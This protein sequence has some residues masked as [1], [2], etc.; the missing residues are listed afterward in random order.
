MKEVYLIGCHISNPAGRSYLEDLCL[1]LHAE[2][3]DFV[4]SSHTNVPL[5]C[6]ELS[7]GFIYNPDNFTVKMW[8]LKSKGLF[9]YYDSFFEIRSNII[10]HGS[11]LDFYGVAGLNLLR[12]GIDFLM[13]TDYE[14]IHWIEYD[15]ELNQDLEKEL[16]LKINDHDA[17]FIKQKEGS[18]YSGGRISFKKSRINPRLMEKSDQEILDS[19]SSVNYFTEAFTHQ[20]LILGNSFDV[21]LENINSMNR[22]KTSSSRPYDWSL[23]EYAGYIGLFLKNKTDTDF[24]VFLQ[25]D[26]ESF[27][28]I[29]LKKFCWWIGEISPIKEFKNFSIWTS[30]TDRVDLDLSG[31]NYQKI[32]KDVIFRR[33]Q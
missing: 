29:F 7:K 22:N 8:D 23:Y 24:D 27:P 5:E 12:N 19:M 10:G 15:I 4:I 26:G 14:I 21:V 2:N 17:V 9:H 6:I 20:N 1:Q 33:F 28:P 30:E 31:N 11:G 32:V 3:K 18:L 16:G 25:I 13:R